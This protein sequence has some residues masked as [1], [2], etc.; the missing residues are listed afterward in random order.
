M[1]DMRVLRTVVLVGVL[2]V[3]C[4]CS[5]EPSIEDTETAWMDETELARVD[6]DP[7]SITS[8]QEALQDTSLNEMLSDPV[9]D[10]ARN[11]EVD[12]DQTGSLQ[13]LSADDT[14]LGEALDVEDPLTAT[15]ALRS[16]P[17]HSTS[18]G[19]ADRSQHWIAQN[20]AI[21]PWNY[22]TGKSTDMPL[23]PRRCQISY[24]RA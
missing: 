20:S 15:G 11:P 16:P 2:T 7:L 4:S 6:D 8:S 21:Y 9:E 10:T 23:A 3:V 24:W 13:G 14:G 22:S 12:P 18:V 5:A 17:V 1:P 19:S